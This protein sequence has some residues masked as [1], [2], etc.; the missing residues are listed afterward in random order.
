MGPA[1]PEEEAN[2]CQPSPLPGGG[3]A[4]ADFRGPQT[5]PWQAPAASR[6]RQALWW[7]HAGPSIR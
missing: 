4:A 7:A 3:G 6:V 1:L 2:I 5:L